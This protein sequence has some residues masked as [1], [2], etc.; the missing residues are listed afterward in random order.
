MNRD[1]L[2]PGH[3]SMCMLSL[4]TMGSGTVRRTWYL[5]LPMSSSSETDATTGETND[6]FGRSAPLAAGVGLSTDGTFSFVGKEV[7]GREDGGTGDGL[8]GDDDKEQ[9]AKGAHE[10]KRGGGMDDRTFADGNVVDCWAGNRTDEDG[11]DGG[12]VEGTGADDDGKERGGMGIVGGKGDGVDDVGR[13]DDGIM[14]FG[15]DDGVRAESGKVKD[16]RL[17]DGRV[18]GS[19]AMRRAI[20]GQAGQL[21][22]GAAPP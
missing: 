14:D 11:E 15:R 10:G 6:C 20:T 7:D 13:G 5:L 18:A 4:R 2:V 3:E 19:G 9:D 17:K 1:L 8:V 16:G 21:L 22:Q 12:G